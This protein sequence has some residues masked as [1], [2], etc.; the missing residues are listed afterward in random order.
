GDSSLAQGW[1]GGMGIGGGGLAIALVPGAESLVGWRAPY[2]TAV[3]MAV[4]TLGALAMS[5]S[6]R[7]V[8]DLGAATLRSLRSLGS[9][10]I[11]RLAAI[12]AGTMGVGFVTSSWAVPFLTRE[13]YG[14][15]LAG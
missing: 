11:Y 10:T 1:V 8:A 6:A 7:P 13:G 9:P 5:P 15:E 2:V 4:L 14:L 3:G 12:Q